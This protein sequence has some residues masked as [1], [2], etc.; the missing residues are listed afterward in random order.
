MSP[1][2]GR[3][4]RGLEKSE[5]TVGIDWL[6][7]HGFG[8][9]RLEIRGPLGPARHDDRSLGRH[10]RIAT[11]RFEERSPVHDRHAE[12]EEH[13]GDT[14][15]AQD[16]EPVPDNRTRLS[17][18][19]TVIRSASICMSDRSLRLTSVARSPSLLLVGT[20]L[21][22]VVDLG[23]ADDPF[24]QIGGPP[25][26]RPG[27]D[28]TRQLDDTVCDVDHDLGLLGNRIERQRLR[29][30]SSNRAIQP[31]DRLRLDE[32]HDRADPSTTPSPSRVLASSRVPTMPET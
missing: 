32:V 18:T 31:V 30:R 13:H 29:D 25:A 7:E 15:V 14:V 16:I 6:H 8:S 20:D 21:Q 22:V 11:F 1:R 26:L 23:H 12:V 2:V 5:Q 27:L 24:G 3:S 19:W 28:L 17:S 9:E 4:L 10:G